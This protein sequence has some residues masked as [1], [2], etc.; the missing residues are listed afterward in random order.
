[1]EYLPFL[2][3]FILSW[4]IVSQFKSSAAVLIARKSSGV[5]QRPCSWASVMSWGGI[6]SGVEKQMCHGNFSRCL[7]EVSPGDGG[8]SSRVSRWSKWVEDSLR[9]GMGPIWTSVFPQANKQV[10]LN[11]GGGGICSATSSPPQTNTCWWTK[12]NTWKFK[13]KVY[14]YEARCGLHSGEGENIKGIWNLSMVYA[15]VLNLEFCFIVM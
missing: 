15:S 6:W 2:I 5:L 7:N 1:M 3:W 11:E 10:E 14:P 12:W 13:N 9:T 8:A 4:F